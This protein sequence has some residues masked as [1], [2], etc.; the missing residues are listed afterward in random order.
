MKKLLCVLL[1]LTML[2]LFVS[3]GGD[4]KEDTD[5]PSQSPGL[6]SS[7]TAETLDGKEVN[8]SIF[9][10]KITMVNIWATFCG[11]C[12]REMPDLQKLS[13][14]YA[15]KGFQIVGIC[16]DIYKAGDVF[17]EGSINEAKKIVEE[18]GV[19]YLNLLPS[20]D[21]KKA[22]IDSVTSVPETFF[23]DE[24]GNVLGESFIG[25]RSYDDWAKIIDS[26]LESYK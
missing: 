10:G 26:V 12:I 7:F 14:D 9:E 15:D 24:K 21:L 16:C 4:N 18:T 22:K 3:C 17:D 6:L 1:S 2:F 25:S 8:E 13:E 23:V 20:D 11:P 5:K 19:K